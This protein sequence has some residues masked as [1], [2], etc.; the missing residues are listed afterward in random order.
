LGFALLEYFYLKDR[1]TEEITT[2]E[3]F[4]TEIFNE[5]SKENKDNK[6][7]LQF[8][9]EYLKKLKE[10]I[11]LNIDK[12]NYLNEY[13]AKELERINKSEKTLFNYYSIII[14]LTIIIAVFGI[15]LIF[16]G[17]KTVGFITIILDILPASTTLLINKA[18]KHLREDRY[19]TLSK[20]QKHSDDFQ[21]K[22]NTLQAINRTLII[23]E[24]EKRNLAILELTQSL[25][26]QKI[27]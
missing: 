18:Y 11:E 14:T 25:S 13:Y 1:Q 9:L 10:E 15:I 20:I 24:S 21:Q 3:S 22:Q 4:K 19:K 26:Q 17:L 5:I 7:R 23:D 8:S 27:S 16:L 6:D 12:L 2:L